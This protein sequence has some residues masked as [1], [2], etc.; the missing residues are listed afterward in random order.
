M[1]YP[2][3]LFVYFVLF[4][5]KFYTKIMLQ[6]IQTQIVGVEGEHDDHLS[7]ATA[8]TVKTLMTNHFLFQV[9][10]HLTR[11]NASAKL[12]LRLLSISMQ[13]FV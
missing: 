8:E 9:V 13:Q 6:R 4:K 1:D 5:H 10:K 3:P 7:T 2:R 11:V 12:L